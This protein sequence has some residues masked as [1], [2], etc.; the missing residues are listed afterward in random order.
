[1]H[2]YLPL[3]FFLNALSHIPLVHADD[4]CYWTYYLSSYADDKCGL[5]GTQQQNLQKIQLDPTGAQ[6][7]SFTGVD[8]PGYILKKKME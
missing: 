4:P 2:S 6:V 8:N 7:H 5:Y 1:M 3:A